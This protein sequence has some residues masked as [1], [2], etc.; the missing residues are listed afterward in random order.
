MTENHDSQGAES[1]GE[2]HGLQGPY[3]PN[4]RLV[5]SFLVSLNSASTRDWIVFTHEYKRRQ[6]AGELARADAALAEAVNRGAL[7]DARDAVVGPVVQLAGRIASAPDGAATA[8]GLDL[9]DLAEAVLAGAL[10]LV[11]APLM[12]EPEARALL[13]HLEKFVP[14]SSAG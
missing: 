11:A 7:E 1:A 14:D 3:G 8:A 10:A 12:P 5:R 9:D 13:A 2:G 6:D 4:T